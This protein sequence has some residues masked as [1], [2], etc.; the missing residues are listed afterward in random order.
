MFK[1]IDVRVL[2]LEQIKENVNKDLYEFIH[3][4]LIMDC[5]LNYEFENLI[6]INN[7][8]GMVEGACETIKSEEKDSD[9]KYEKAELKLMKG[10]AK[11]LMEQL[12]S[13]PSGVVIAAKY[14]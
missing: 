4:E 14:E 7:F 1:L 3:D 8:I 10:Q 12:K 5:Q 11:E 13:L 6:P 9:S 2:P